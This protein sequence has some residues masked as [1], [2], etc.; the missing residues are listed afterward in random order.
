MFTECTLRERRYRAGQQFPND[1]NYESP[2]NPFGGSS[3]FDDYQ[4]SICDQLSRV[5][6][7]KVFC[8]ILLWSFTV[9]GA[10]DPQ[11]F[12]FWVS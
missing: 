4:F 3:V 2:C 8:D 12:L 11:N 5:V 9:P 10:E 6:I 1:R 7:T